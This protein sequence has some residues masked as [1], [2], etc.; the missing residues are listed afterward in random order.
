MKFLITTLT[1]A[2][3]C[4]VL[5]T[6]LHAQEDDQGYVI[7]EY[8]KVKPGMY[9]QYLECESIWKTIHQERQ[10]AGIIE[11]W[12][13]EEVLYPSG[14]DNEY[15]FITITFFKNWDA[16]GKMGES[17]NEETWNKVTQSLSS[18]QEEIA[19]RAE[20]FRDI[21]KREIWT[22]ADMAFGTEGDDQPKFRVENF[23]QIPSNGWDAW[24]EMETELAKPVHVKNIELGNRAG[25]ALTILVMPHG[26][27][28][29]YQASTVDFYDS[30]EQMNSNEGAAWETTHP[31]MSEEQV[32]SRIEGTRTLVRSEARMLI[33]YTE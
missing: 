8:M 28:L 31:N 15:D 4:L 5:P 10:K 24:M 27:G 26:A 14:T 6:D 29:P 12:E 3:C 30:W 21:V 11:G 23:M 18:E 17:W 16:I 20:E 19:D 25:W 2:L 7:V 33:L 22:A 9:D 1:L 13:L 32:N